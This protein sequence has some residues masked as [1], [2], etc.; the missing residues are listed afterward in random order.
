MDD[1][2]GIAATKWTDDLYLSVWNVNQWANGNAFAG[3]ANSQYPTFTVDS[4]G[5]LY[6]AWIN[7][8]NATVSYNTVAGTNGAAG[9]SADVFK[10]YDPSEFVDISIDPAN[11]NPA[12]AYIQNTYGGSGAWSN[13][14]SGSVNVWVSDITKNNNNELWEAY[15]NNP[16][17]VYYGFL[18]DGLW[19]NSQLWEYYGVKVVRSGNNLHVVW[20]DDSTKSV[21]YAYFVSTQNVARG[22]AAGNYYVQEQPWINL[23][24]SRDGADVN[25]ADTPQFTAGISRVASVGQSVSIDVDKNNDPVIGYYDNVNHVMRVAYANSATP[26]AVANWHIQAVHPSGDSLDSFAGANS[27]D[28]NGNLTIRINHTSG[29]VY[30]IS[31]RPTKGQLIYTTAAARGAG[32]FSFGASS[33]L[34]TNGNVGSWSAM[35]VNTASDIPAMVYQNKNGLGTDDGVKVAYWDTTLSTPDWETV[36]APATTFVDDGKLSIVY[37]NG[38]TG[39]PWTLAVGFKSTAFQ[40]MYLQPQN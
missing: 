8:A 1:G 30:L 39:V 38:Y 27:G 10:L 13:L 4:S 25:Y 32:D 15:Q 2:S 19:H 21:K 6:G 17:W 24:G 9:T 22:G 23:D 33:V 28:K 36:I 7:Y 31:Y 5:T 35:S 14:N 11:N 12:I 16:L 20:Y 40:V 34:D 3:S 26:T 29:S 37:N 18:T